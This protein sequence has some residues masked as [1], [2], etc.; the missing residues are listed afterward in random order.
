MPRSERDSEDSTGV[1]NSDLVGRQATFVGMT[2]W[3][4]ARSNWF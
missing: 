1:L 3:W 2:G 4:A